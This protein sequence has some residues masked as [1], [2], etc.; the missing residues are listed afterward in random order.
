SKLSKPCGSDLTR[1]GRVMTRAALLGIGS[2]K[3]RNCLRRVKPLK[4]DF[5]I[6]RPGS[7]GQSSHRPACVGASCE[8]PLG[9]T[10]EFASIPT[11]ASQEGPGES[12]AQGPCQGYSEDVGRR[13]RLRRWR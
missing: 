3:A 6:S 9:R 7:T 1:R 2:E 12:Q 4:F 8:W 11:R 10:V 5:C 13:T